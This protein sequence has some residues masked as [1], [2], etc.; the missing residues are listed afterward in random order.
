MSTEDFLRL[1]EAGYETRNIEFKPSY[2]WSVPANIWMREK[3]IQT[4]LG[5]VNTR[6]GGSVIIGI[7]EDR[8]GINPRINMVGMTEEEI[9][10]FNYDIL[11][12]IIDSFASSNTEFDISEA[13]HDGKKYLVIQVNEFEEFPVIC[14]RNGQYINESR[15]RILREGDV[16]CRSKKGRPSTIRVSYNEIKEIIESSIDKG[17]KK[18]KQRGYVLEGM[19]SPKD[20]LDEQVKDLE[21]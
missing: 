14:K 21:S 15:D 9:N 1:V 12:S 13:F 4:I 11:K 20:M 19:P 7:E 2:I 6:D 3:M 8:N 18:L 16:Y 17:N 5:L 10:S